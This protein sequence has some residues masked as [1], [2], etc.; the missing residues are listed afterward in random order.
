MA[1]KSV[2]TSR[3]KNTLARRSSAQPKATST[4]ARAASERRQ[5]N[6]PDRQKVCWIPKDVRRVAT[7]T[8]ADAR[9]PKKR[10]VPCLVFCGDWLRE[11]GFPPGAPILVRVVVRGQLVVDRFL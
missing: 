2:T 1:R 6:R 9:D 11:A 10:K 4:A 3:N 8:R 5:R 7:V